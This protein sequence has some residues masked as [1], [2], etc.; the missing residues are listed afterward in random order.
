MFS[1]AFLAQFLRDRRVAAIQPSSGR[2]IRRVL[3]EIRPRHGMTVIELGPGDGAATFP[4]LAALPGD[5]RY[6]AIEKNPVF[7]EKL[8]AADDGRLEVIRGDANDLSS[9]LAVRGIK[10]ADVI[11]ASIPFTYLSPAARDA[12]TAAVAGSLSPR[13]TF[14]V[15]HQ[16][17]PLM[18]PML[19]RRFARVKTEFEPL[20]LF[21]CFVMTAREPRRKS[22]KFSAS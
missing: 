22:R 1:P 9:L 3:R 19:R 6:L 4:L 14:V 5:T 13:G 20:N 15:F 18:L 7:A 16:Y 11:I 2:L 10:K 17:S 12:L 21:P 8:A